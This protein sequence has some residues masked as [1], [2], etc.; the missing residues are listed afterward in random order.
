MCL[1]VVF[2]LIFLT[3]AILRLKGIKY[4]KLSDATGYFDDDFNPAYTPKEGKS[5]Q[6]IKLPLYTWILLIVMNLTV[7]VI[8]GVVSYWVLDVYL[9]EAYEDTFK[10]ATTSSNLRLGI[11]KF[12]HKVTIILSKATD[13]LNYKI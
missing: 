5:W 10:Y 6:T 4:I 7:P 13:W 3:L 8:G 12:I 9:T 2:N 1:G 11:N